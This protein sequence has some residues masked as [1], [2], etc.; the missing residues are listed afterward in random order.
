M[1]DH[2]ESV[3]IEFDPQII[4]YEQLLSKFWIMHDAT[5][6]CGRQYRSAIWYQTE[7]Q[8]Q[9]IEKSKQEQMTMPRYAGRKIVTHIAPLGDFYLAEDYHQKYLD[10]SLKGKLY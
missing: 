8:K 7:E 1:G 10:R 2:T 3:Q 5:M 6:K 9:A 4:S